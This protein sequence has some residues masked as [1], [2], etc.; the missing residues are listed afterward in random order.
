M[1][2]TPDTQKLLNDKLQEFIVT[3]TIPQEELGEYGD[4][5][6]HLFQNEDGVFNI[7][8]TE[9]DIMKS[10]QYFGNRPVHTIVV[11]NDRIRVG[12]SFLA[13]CNNRDLNGKLFKF[14]SVEGDGII[15]VEDK[16]GKETKTTINLLST[17]FKFVRKGNKEDKER[18]VNGI[19][20]PIK[21]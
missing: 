13:V 3:K 14:S 17:S 18:V 21:D 12:D 2:T 20:K 5:I 16:D 7:C 11:S 6:G 9:E 15:N 10:N 19:I 8:N 4:Y 1:N